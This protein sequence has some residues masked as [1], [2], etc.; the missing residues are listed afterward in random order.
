[1]LNNIYFV[2]LHVF[3]VHNAFFFIEQYKAEQHDTK[4]TEH[5]LN[6]TNKV[7][8]DYTKYKM[9]ISSSQKITVARFKI[10]KKRKIK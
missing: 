6:S 5:T 7:K 4:Q 3:H 2:A 8:P 9:I 1:M 10:K